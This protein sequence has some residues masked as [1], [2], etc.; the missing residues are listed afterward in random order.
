M[1]RELRMSVWAC[2]SERCVSLFWV[3]VLRTHVF[4]RR[5]AETVCSDEAMEMVRHR[6]NSTSFSLSEN[7]ALVCGWSFVKHDAASWTATHLDPL[8]FVTSASCLA[9]LG[10]SILSLSSRRSV[11]SSSGSWRASRLTLLPY[12]ALI[13]AL[14]FSKFLQCCPRHLKIPKTQCKAQSCC[15]HTSDCRSQWC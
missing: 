12:A 9:T 8:S 4:K 11:S 6:H 3:R 10:P 5:K 7:I 15:Q 13:T 1:S 2:I 14:S